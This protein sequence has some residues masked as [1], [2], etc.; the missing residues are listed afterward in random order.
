[1]PIQDQKYRNIMQPKVN[2]DYHLIEENLYSTL[3]NVTGAPYDGKAKAYESLVSSSIYNSIIWGTL[4]IDYT[5]FAR[6][7]ILSASGSCIDVGCG[8]LIQTASVYSVCSQDLVLLDYSI[9]MLKIAKQ[10]LMKGRTNFPANICLL[11][12]DAFH[13]PFDAESFDNVCS[14]GL[15]HCFEDKQA[16]IDELLRVLKVNGSFH[17]TS[18]TSDRLIS[19]YYM[20]LLQRKQAFGEPLSSGEILHLFDKQAVELSFYKK[21]SMI[22]ISGHKKK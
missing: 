17:F 1:M 6:K 22:F 2:K 3:P 10:R 15:I 9:D 14:F 21:G 13:L 8:G 4:P 5:D 11:Q 7:A 20:K 12:S 19:K 16:F 18:L